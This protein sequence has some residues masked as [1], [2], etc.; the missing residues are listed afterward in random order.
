M[1]ARGRT[2]AFLSVS[3]SETFV[4]L[5]DVPLLEHPLGPIDAIL[6]AGQVG[7]GELDF[8]LDRGQIPGIVHLFI[9]LDGDLGEL[10]GQL[11][12]LIGGFGFSCGQLLRT[13]PCPRRGGRRLFVACFEI[14]GCGVC[15]VVVV[16]RFETGCPSFGAGS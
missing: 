1:P 16:G 5:R 6:G 7:F 12:D 10:A 15:A 11:G 13:Q 9:F 4:G 8:T 14:F 2:R 3:S